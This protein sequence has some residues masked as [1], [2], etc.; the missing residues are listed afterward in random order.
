MKFYE[1]V[2]FMGLM[3]PRLNSLLDSLQRSTCS[4]QSLE[5]LD[6]LSVKIQNL[7]T[8]VRTQ[9]TGIV[10]T[11]NSIENILESTDVTTSGQRELPWGN[12]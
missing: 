9:L 12:P 11:I 5:E 2:T 10:S 6:M 7:S 8:L 4:E 3:R 1:G